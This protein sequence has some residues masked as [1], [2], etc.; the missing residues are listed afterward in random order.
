MRRWQ[1]GHF[2]LSRLLSICRES[3]SACLTLLFS[4]ETQPY[5][6][7]LHGRQCLT[8]VLLVLWDHQFAKNQLIPVH[9]PSAQSGRAFK[10]LK[11]ALTRE[12]MR[13][14]Q[15]GVIISRRTIHMNMLFP[16]TAPWQCLLHKNGSSCHSLQRNLFFSEFSRSRFQKAASSAVSV[17]T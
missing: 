6:A 5:F 4:A 9:I 14:G 10:S 3:C 15:E 8:Q 2:H 17:Q 1:K 11:A 16:V 7:L 13:K 12:S